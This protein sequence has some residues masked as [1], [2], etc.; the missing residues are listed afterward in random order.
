[1]VIDGLMVPR[2]GIGGGPVRSPLDPSTGVYTQSSV[3]PSTN[4]AATTAAMISP[5]VISTRQTATN[6]GGFQWLQVDYGEVRPMDVVRVRT[7]NNELEGGWGTYTYVNGCIVEISD[8]GVEW[9]WIAI[10]HQGV[11]QFSSTQN[12][13]AVILQAGQ[14]VDVPLPPNTQARYVRLSN[15][16]N[17]Y[18]AVT[19]FYAA[20][21]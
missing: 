9:E 12:V 13:L 2:P 5:T 20:T 15:P 4:D 17:G 6:S 7:P 11:F 19:G 3:Y 21:R 18:V 1:M 14:F 10:L 8:D 16:N